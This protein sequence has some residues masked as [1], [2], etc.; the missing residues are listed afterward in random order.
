MKLIGA[1]ASTMLLTASLAAAQPN[2][3]VRMTVTTSDGQPHELSAPESG[4]ATLSLRD[5]TEIGVRP[6]IVDS[7]P[8][9]RVIVTFFKM[10]TSSDAG[11]EIGAVEVKT[12]A[13]AVQAKTSP[14]FRVA[15]NGVSEAP[16]PSATATR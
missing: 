6:T 2:P 1:F 13:P 4:L 14:A 9:T 5:G 8:W 10:P 15:V 3:V 12:G 7:K 11:E 16:A